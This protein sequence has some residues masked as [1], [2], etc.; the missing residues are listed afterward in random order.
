MTNKFTEV[1][2]N[3]EIWLMKQRNFSKMYFYIHIQ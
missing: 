1:K 3:Y 2:I